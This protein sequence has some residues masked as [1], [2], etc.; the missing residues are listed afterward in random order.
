MS[1]PKA[2]AER[3]KGSVTAS[4]GIDVR[5]PDLLLEAAATILAQEALL[6]R[7]GEG[8]R[9][10]AEATR[11]ADAAYEH[12]RAGGFVPGPNTLPIAYVGIDDFRLASDLLREME[13]A[14][15]SD[16]EPRE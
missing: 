7:M 8:L 4:R 3:L 6:A 2:L 10:F 1:D 15:A 14:R 16:A 11:M 5:D 12:A 13:A 9:P